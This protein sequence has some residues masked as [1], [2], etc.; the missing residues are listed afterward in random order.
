MN[1]KQRLESA[2]R[3]TVFNTLSNEK[4]PGEKRLNQINRDP[5]S[6]KKLEVN[7]LRVPQT[8]K[9]IS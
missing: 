2:K 4:V 5:F 8:H 6:K 9:Q 3:N 1:F 7:F